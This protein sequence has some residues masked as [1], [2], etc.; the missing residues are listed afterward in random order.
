MHDDYEVRCGLD[1]TPLSQKRFDVLDSAVERNNGIPQERSRHTTGL[2]PTPG[3]SSAPKS[4]RLL[5]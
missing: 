2:A 3:S 4:L 5:L 1:P